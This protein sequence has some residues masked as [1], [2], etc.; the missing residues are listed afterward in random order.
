M[1][2]QLLTLAAS[3]ITASLL[4]A[5]S[6]PADT[7]KAAT[8]ALAAKDNYSWKTIIEFGSNEGTVE[9]K[10]DKNG[11]TMLNISGGDQS[12]DAV[13]K[14]G[15]GA[16]KVEGA[17]KTLA[18]AVEE[19]QPGAARFISRMLQNFK[20]PAAEAEDIAGKVKEL[21]MADD[22]YSGDLTEEGVKSLLSFG[23]RSGGTPPEVTGAKG[24][25]KFWVKDGTLTKYEYKVQGTITFNGNERDASRKNTVEIKD[26]GTTKVSV[27]EEAAK[28]LS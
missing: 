20:A 9:G 2:K 12:M 1:K 13:L 28:K 17:W 3:L 23:R 21:K 24:S 7:V 25:A 26:V 5:D 22:V 11:A 27:P 16:M 19:G 15:K 14:G 6:S 8:K 4:A 10:A 18:E